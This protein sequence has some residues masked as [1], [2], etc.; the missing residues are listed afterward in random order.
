MIEH[1]H[2]ATR[3]DAAGSRHTGSA[4]GLYRGRVMHE[5]SFPSHHRLD[6]GVWYL[7]ADLDEL[8]SL[9]A[10]V[11]GFGYNRPA[12][13]SFWERDHGARDG[14]PLRPW[15]ERHLLEAGLDLEGGSIRILCFPRVFGYGF[16][17]I[18]VWFCH[19]PAGELR[20]ICY[21]VSNTFGEWHDYLVPVSAGDITANGRGASVRTSFTKELFVSPFI[22]MDATYDFTT[23]V[24]DERVSMVVRESVSAG[25]VLIASLG[26]R[27]AEITSARLL[28]TLLRYPLVTLKVIGGIHWEALKLWRKGAPYRR[29][30]APPPAPVTIVE[31]LANGSRHRS[32]PLDRTPSVERVSLDTVRG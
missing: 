16:N 20:A 11:R 14:S 5:R 24:P 27:R 18:S 9:D 19:G 13:V 2:A 31:P 6:Y 1:P 30:G 7:L 32:L 22:D 21:E 26:A 12:P 23:R 17:P 3:P 25:R 15:I 8:P 28:A 10:R 4:S 29:R